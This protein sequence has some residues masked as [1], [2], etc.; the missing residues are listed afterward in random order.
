MRLPWIAQNYQSNAYKAWEVYSTTLRLIES[1]Q[2]NYE[3]SEKLLKLISQKFQLGQ[4]TTVDV[5]QAQQSFETAGYRLINL[6]YTAKIA[7]ITLKQLTY[8][9]GQ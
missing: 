3:L 2:K 8:Q 9:L 1:E 7:E 4:A 6:N 5:K